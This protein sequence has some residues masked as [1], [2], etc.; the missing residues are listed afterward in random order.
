MKVWL[1]LKNLDRLTDSV[2]RSVVG[3]KFGFGHEGTPR[4]A[5]FD[6]GP[7]VTPAE[8]D[9]DRWIAFAP[10]VMVSECFSQPLEVASQVRGTAGYREGDVLFADSKALVVQVQGNKIPQKRLQGWTLSQTL[11][12]QPH[13]LLIDDFFFIIRQF[14]RSCR[15]VTPCLTKIRR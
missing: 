10:L 14:A 7:V 11:L 13:G 2:S 4:F 12:A 6:H 8:G 9:S 3:K 5:V 1:P 15:H